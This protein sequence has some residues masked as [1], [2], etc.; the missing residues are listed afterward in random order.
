MRSLSF[1]DHVRSGDATAA[2]GRRFH[3]VINIGI[4]GSDLGPVMVSRALSPCRDEHSP[5]VYYVSNVD[6]AHLAD[7]TAG[8]DPAC[9]LV[10]IASK[11]FTTQETMA[12]ARAARDWL[13]TAVPEEGLA[14]HMAAL[15]TNLEATREFGIHDARVFGFWDWVGGRYS[16]WSSIGLSVA[17]SVGAEPF[18]EIP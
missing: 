10:L 15:S 5:D 6:G 8:L 7:I 17:L 2:N 4:G 12:N 1:A 16:V 18:R 3:N 14:R 9:T 13:R 11:T